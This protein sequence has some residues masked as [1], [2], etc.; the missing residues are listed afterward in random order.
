[1][2]QLTS[3]TGAADSASNDHRTSEE[4][5][6]HRRMQHWTFVEGTPAE[7]AKHTPG[8][9]S[10]LECQANPDCKEWAISCSRPA[11]NGCR[12]NPRIAICEEMGG[13]SIGE[14]E[15]RA[16][17]ILI[18]SAPSLLNMLERILAEVEEG[19][20]CL[21]TREHARNAIARAKGGVK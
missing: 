4:L 10:V 7:V 20:V 18:A 15:G 16:N 3:Q 5:N 13:S 19:S 6:S 2:N 21:L 1:M 17:A 11:K 14:D 9:W 12:E 8:P